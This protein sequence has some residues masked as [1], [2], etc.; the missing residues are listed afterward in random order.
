MPFNTA[1]TTSG[2]EIYNA[3]PT[4]RATMLLTPV[5]TAALNAQEVRLSTH[6]IAREVIRC[7]NVLMG[8]GNMR[9]VKRRNFV[10]DLESGVQGSPVW[11]SER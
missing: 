6:R 2:P 1:A 7:I 8:T 11:R 3:H 5:P 9:F 10:M 4:S